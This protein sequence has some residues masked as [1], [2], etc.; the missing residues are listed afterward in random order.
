MDETEALAKLRWRDPIEEEDR[1]F[2]LLEGASITIGRASYNDI[3]IPEQHVSRQH[4]VVQYREGLFMI[5]DL[6][7]SNGTYVNDQ[8]I[9]KPFPLSA[10][11]K[12]R[13]Y[14]PEMDFLAL[15]T[16]DLEE[17]EETGQIFVAHDRGGGVLLVT[18]GPQEGQSFALQLDQITIGRATSNATWEIGLQDPSVSRPHAQ[19]R[20]SGEQWTLYDLNSSNGTSVNNQRVMKSGCMLTDGDIVTLGASILMFRIGWDAPP[21]DNERG[22]PTAPFK[23]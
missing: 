14:V 21:A 19:I 20:R 2:V 6:G 16:G 7:S 17:A 15:Q 1:E 8:R 12:I 10:G 3:R 13:L 4:A 23:G 22:T 9:L 5:N 11:D 18:N